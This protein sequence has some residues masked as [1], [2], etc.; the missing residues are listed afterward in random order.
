[1]ESDSFYSHKLYNV[2]EIE[3]LYHNNGN[4]TWAE[5]LKLK[6]LGVVFLGFAEYRI[7]DKRKWLFAKIK[8]GI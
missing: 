5:F 8:Y 7:Q 3:Y 6:D 1:M 2:F 4:T